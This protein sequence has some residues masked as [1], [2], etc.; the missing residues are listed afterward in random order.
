[1]WKSFT[2]KFQHSVTNILGFTFVRIRPHL[3]TKYRAIT[4]SLNRWGKSKNM[5]LATYKAIGGLVINY[6]ATI[7]ALETNE[8][9][10]KQLQ[11]CQNTTLRIVIFWSLL[12]K[13]IKEKKHRSQF[14]FGH[15]YI[16]KY[17]YNWRFVT[18]EAIFGRARSPPCGVPLDVFPMELTTL[19]TKLPPN[20]RGAPG[21][22]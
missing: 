16:H 18:A 4:K 15:T 1:M 2:S 17:M 6:T 21:I 13:R 10:L 19:Y 20:C 7:W 11:V 9:L 22:R 8:M 3:L 12:Q 5:L 14:Y